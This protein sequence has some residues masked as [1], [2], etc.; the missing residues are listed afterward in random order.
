MENPVIAADGHSYERGAIE[1]WFS[2]G[3]NTSPLTGLRL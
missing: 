1:R 2:T 3:H